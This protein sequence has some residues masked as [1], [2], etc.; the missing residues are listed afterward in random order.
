[1]FRSAGPGYPFGAL[2]PSN[3]PRISKWFSNRQ[4]PEIIR[5]LK[6]TNKCSFIKKN[7]H[8]LL[9]ALSSVGWNCRARAYTKQVKNQS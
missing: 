2:S 1:M 8:F 4:F 7:N 3:L 6:G 9:L 5:R